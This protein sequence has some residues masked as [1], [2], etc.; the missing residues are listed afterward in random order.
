MKFSKITQSAL[1]ASIIVAA[2]LA[3]SA[4]DL[5]LNQSVATTQSSIS[6]AD[7]M[8]LAKRHAQGTIANVSLDDSGVYDVTIFSKNYEHE[9]SVN[10]RSGEILRTERSSLDRSDKRKLRALN[11]VKIKQNDA[12]DRAVKAVGGGQAVEIEFDKERRLWVYD[13]KVVKNG[14]QY[15]VRINANT[16]AVLKQQIDY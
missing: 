13:V 5:Q 6:L 16:G 10:A 15:D 1:L 11:S 3:A 8:N 4:D 12:A 2:P 7:A 9:V 14:Q